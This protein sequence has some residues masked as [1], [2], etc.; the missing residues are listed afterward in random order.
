VAPG[1]GV[2]APQA[3]GRSTYCS[4]SD[5]GS[6]QAE[7]AGKYPALGKECSKCKKTGHFAHCCL[8]KGG[9]VRAAGAVVAVPVVAVQEVA[10]TGALTVAAEEEGS[11]YCVSRSWESAQE[12]TFHQ[13]G[14][15]EVP[16]QPHQSLASGGVPAGSGTRAKK[17][18]LV[19]GQ[20]PAGQDVL[21]TAP[22]AVLRT[23]GCAV[24]VG[25][26][27]WWW[28]VAELFARGGRLAVKTFQAVRPN[29]S[30]LPVAEFPEGKLGVEA[31][32]QKDQGRIAMVGEQHQVCGRDSVWRQRSV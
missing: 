12:E 26:V 9:A 7:R 16:G 8:S 18:L 31:A 24:V 32:S 17:Q 21:D 23:V 5:H 13:E 11:F 22:P 20:L 2:V 10:Q 3:K 30:V 14:E 1:R 6:S 4:R 29:W 25:L 19:E 27:L 28:S 15:A